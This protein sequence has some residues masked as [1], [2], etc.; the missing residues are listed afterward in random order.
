MIRT[1]SGVMIITTNETQEFRFLLWF[2]FRGRCWSLCFWIFVGTRVDP[3]FSS[4]STPTIPNYCPFRLHLRSRCSLT[5]SSYGGVA[6]QRC[7]QPREISSGSN[8]RTIKHAY[9][10]YQ[11]RC[12]PH[13][14]QIYHSNAIIVY[15]GRITQHK[16]H[17]QV[18]YTWF[19]LSLGIRP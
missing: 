10:T 13:T 11:L 18:R 9:I 8:T 17:T 3:G 15:Q 12:I 2:L 4:K 14:Y 1:V 19:T 7:L 5:R 16:S 6:G